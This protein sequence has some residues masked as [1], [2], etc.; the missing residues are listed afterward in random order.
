[1]VLHL[2]VHTGAALAPQQWAPS[3]YASSS[4]SLQ[5]INDWSSTQSDIQE[6]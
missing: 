3:K 5:L 2:D 1:M 4:S 6:L